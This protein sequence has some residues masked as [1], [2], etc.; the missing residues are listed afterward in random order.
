VPEWRG[1]ICDGD[2]GIMELQRVT[3]SRCPNVS[4][5]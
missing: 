2:P 1:I 3:S 5:G 4:V